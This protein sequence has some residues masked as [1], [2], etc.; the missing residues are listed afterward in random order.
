MMLTML[1]VPK[2]VQAGEFKAK[3]LELMDSVAKSGAVVVITKRGKPVA[4][5]SPVVTKPATLVGYRGEQIEFVGDAVTPVD[6][7]WTSVGSRRPAG[8]KRRR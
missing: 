6:V 7:D 1:P 8:R 4:Q 5:L 2:V 3:C